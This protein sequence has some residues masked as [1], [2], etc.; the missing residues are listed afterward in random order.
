MYLSQG[1]CTQ[2]TSFGE[3][4]ILLVIAHPDD[5]VMFFSPLLTSLSMNKLDTSIVSV[6]CLSNGNAEGLGTIRTKELKKC[7]SFFNIDAERVFIVDHNRL[8]DGMDNIWPEEV[9]SDIIIEFTRL[10]SPDVVIS[11]D[12]RGVSGHPNHIA[13]FR[14]LQMAY[15]STLKREKP[16]LLALSLQSKCLCRKFSG[17][18]DILLSYVNLTLRREEYVVCS[19]LSLMNAMRGIFIHRSQNLWYRRIFIL[20]SSFSYVNSFNKLT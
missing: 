5:E 10:L 12:E 11:F 7:C 2:F 16:K 14:G 20:L 13:A 6:L 15:T 17:I 1:A 8:Q 4:S 19:L 9:V 18:L 3:H